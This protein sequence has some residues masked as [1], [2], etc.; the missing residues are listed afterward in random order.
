MDPQSL[1][2]EVGLA[3]SSQN[4]PD[5]FEGAATEPDEASVGSAGRTAAEVWGHTATVLA[6]G[7]VLNMKLRRRFE[8]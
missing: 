1:K 5:G 2:R 4:C 3:S 6:E 8:I 7:R